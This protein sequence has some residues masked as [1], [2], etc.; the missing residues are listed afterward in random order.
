MTAARSR[1]LV[2]DDDRDVLEA[3]RLLLRS[4]GYDVELTTSPAG[5][6]AAVGARD[7]DAVLMDM[8]YTRDTTG[9]AEGF[10]LISSLRH[11]DNTLP[12]VVMTA[13]PLCASD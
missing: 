10:D 2:A 9:G 3:L 5:V 8:N 1:L 13:C 12:V 11:L 6:V 7:F 4:E